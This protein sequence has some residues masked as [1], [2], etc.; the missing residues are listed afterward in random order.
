MRWASASMRGRRIAVLASHSRGSRSPSSSAAVR[1]IRAMVA[2]SKSNWPVSWR[3]AGS[4]PGPRARSHRSCC[5]AAVGRATSSTGAAGI[6]SGQASRVPSRNRPLLLA[7][8][9][10]TARSGAA[11]SSAC[12]SRYSTSGS[13]RLSRD[14]S[15][16]TVSRSAGCGGSSRPAA[17]RAGARAARGVGRDGQL[18]GR[19][20]AE[21]L[22]H[23]RRA[24]LRGPGPALQHGG[25]GDPLRGGQAV[26]GP[27]DGGQQR[28]DPV[29]E[30]V[31]PLDVADDPL[32]G[33]QRARGQRLAG[34]LG[35]LDQPPVPQRPAR[36][37]GLPARVGEQLQGEREGGPGQALVALGEGAQARGGRVEFHRRA[38]QQDLLLERGEAQPRGQLDQR[39]PAARR[40]RRPPRPAGPRRPVR[41]SRPAHRP[42]TP[43]GPGP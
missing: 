8:N 36:R 14:H 30:V 32:V 23:R 12:A 5:S 39:R 43:G 9:R 37:Q 27:R 21:Q 38:Q 24:Q 19:V 13:S 6:S 22:D 18:G 17:G 42:R 25:G 20:G 34:R 3:A 28:L 35:D 16:A 41:R 10:P 2:A 33:A 15:R 29:V 31:Q 40:P 4:A 1:A 26:L 11:P 7:R